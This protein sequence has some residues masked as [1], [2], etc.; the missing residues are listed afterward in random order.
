[1]MTLVNSFHGKFVGAPVPKMVLYAFVSLACSSDQCLYWVKNNLYRC[2][3]CLCTSGNLLS[4]I[5]PRS[6][7]LNC[8]A[9]YVWILSL[10]LYFYSHCP[11][12]CTPVNASM[13]TLWIIMLFVMFVTWMLKQSPNTPDSVNG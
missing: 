12:S 6:L 4:D 7:Y 8:V 5:A 3:W 13:F 9:I 10:I 11:A 2:F 1:M